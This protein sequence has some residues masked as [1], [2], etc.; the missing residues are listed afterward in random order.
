MASKSDDLTEGGLARPL[1]HLAWPIVVTQLLQ[2]AYNVG[3]AFWLGRYS[4][5]AVGAISLAF[6]LIYFLIAFGGGFNV[7]GSTLVAQYMGADSDGSAGK[8]AGQTLGFVV[9]VG[10][11]LSAV[12]HFGSGPMLSLF[13]SDAATATSVVPLAEQY[14]EIFFL[15]LPFM[16]GFLAFS[17][18]LRGYG[19]TRTPMR[20]MAVTVVLNVVLDPLL[21]FGVGPVPAL[22]IET[23]LVPEM[24]IEG[25]ALATLLARVVG[26]LVGV[27][28]LFFT[29]TGPD[30]RLDHLAPDFDYVRD[31][32]RIGIPS[33]LEQSAGALAMVMLTVMIVTFEPSVIAAYGLGNRLI[34]LVFLPA[35]GLG[36]ATNTVVGQ[37]LGAGN[38]E[39]AER[40]VRLAASV[41]AGV[42][43]VLAVVAATV[44]QP[45]VE[46][47]MATGTAEAAET[48]EY[49][50]EYLRIRTVEFAFIGVF[51]VLVGAFRGAGNTKVAMVI[52]M[53]TLWVV[54]V[55]AVY[56]LAF[57]T[58]LGPT[59]IWVGVALGHVV[60]AIAA[61][62]W[63]T[64]GTW[65]DA[66][67]D[68]GS[69]EPVAETPVAED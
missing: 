15:G 68:S 19:D 26:G 28:V 3:D 10:V 6:P 47:F 32:V 36:K 59:G 35:V 11:I 51:Q 34:S 54:R 20:V 38:A 65:K 9:L 52:S 45:I 12:G 48:V 53:V 50:V 44:P 42:M 17:A 37:N 4:A 8:V 69:A 21:I 61:A 33:A 24:G 13:P 56:L 57:E 29:N 23:A 30:V 55:P 7:A 2:V 14:M 31:I 63:F 62:A 1:F 5:N 64:R 46:V 40:A 43:L 66:V 58:T 41:G 39:R 22:G 16:F 18:L 25:A 27:Y 60:G 49:A 67:I